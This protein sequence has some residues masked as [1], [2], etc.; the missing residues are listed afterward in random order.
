MKKYVIF[1]GWNNQEC[2]SMKRNVE[3]KNAF[4][5]NNNW[6]HCHKLFY[7]MECTKLSKEG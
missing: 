4:Q 6:T 3:F 2:M 5:I 7:T 1:L